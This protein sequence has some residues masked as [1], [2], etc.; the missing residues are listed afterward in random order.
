[1]IVLTNVRT[2]LRS[3]WVDAE[4]GVQA[5]SYL[6]IAV[7]WAVAVAWSIRA[8]RQERAVVAAE[9]ATQSGQTEVPAGEAEGDAVRA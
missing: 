8:H 5:A 3:D 7:V 6:G 2:I 9:Q 1:V 4:G